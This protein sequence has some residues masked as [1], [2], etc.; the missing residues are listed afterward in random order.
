MNFLQDEILDFEAFPNPRNLV[1]PLLNVN[2]GT[3]FTLFH[4]KAGSFEFN[5][6][7]FPNMHLME[8]GWQSSGDDTQMRSSAHEAGNAIGI[9]FQLGGHLVT[10][11]K[12][13]PNLMDMRPGSHNLAF[14]P[15][16]KDDHFVGRNQRL[17][18]FHLSIDVRYFSQIIG[19]E[20]AWSEMAQRKLEKGEP[21]SGAPSAQDITPRMQTIIGSIRNEQV[22]GPMRGLLLQ[23]RILELLALQLEQFHQNEA[24]SAIPH[25]E[26][27]KLHALKLYLDAH[28]LQDLSLTQLSRVCL[29]N[30]FKLKKG[31]KQLFGSTIFGYLKNLRMEHASRMLQNSAVTIEE[32]ADVLGYEHAHHFSAAF[33]KHFGVNP[34]AYNGRMRLKTG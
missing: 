7:V 15:E 6:V 8:L 25:G 27:E 22:A 2:P 3:P 17:S 10:R 16:P 18:I 34:S 14:A 23:S 26:A 20:D 4:P 13:M 30:E 31:F 5:N 21:F 33:K 11:F 24:P 1:S 28:Y 19:A 9:N 32:V 29:L 12:G